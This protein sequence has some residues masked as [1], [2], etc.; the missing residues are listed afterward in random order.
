M[1]RDGDEEES[2]ITAS[3]TREAA[4]LYRLIPTHCGILESVG[5][6]PCLVK[7]EF[8][9]SDHQGPQTFKVWK[10]DDKIYVEC[11]IPSKRVSVSLYPVF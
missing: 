8:Y 1:S 6:E 2:L 7:V 3:S 10:R 5:G 4:K 11:F 9:N